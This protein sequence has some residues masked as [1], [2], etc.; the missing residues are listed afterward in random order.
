MENTMNI[1][2]LANKVSKISKRELL[3]LLESTYN[4]Q[5][6]HTIQRTLATIYKAIAPTVST[7]TA[8]KDDWSWVC[9]AMAKKDIRYY[10]NYVYCDG[11]RIICTD[12]HRMHTVPNTFG[13]EPGYYDKRKNRVTDIDA[14][15]PNIDRV[16]PCITERKFI[17]FNLSELEIRQAGKIEACLVPDHDYKPAI[18]IDSKY[19]KQAVAGMEQASAYVRTAMDSIRIENGD[20]L[21]VIMPLRV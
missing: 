1:A 21:A 16:I 7:G 12:G 10:L 9:Q 13:L 6:D 19:L 14:R 3:A 4:E 8:A 11:D 5:Q 18:G 2:T 15:Y 20:R 17:E